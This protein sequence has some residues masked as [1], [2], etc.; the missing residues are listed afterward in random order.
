[1]VFTAAGVVLGGGG[2]ASSAFAGPGA[3]P[4]QPPPAPGADPAGAGPGQGG[5][6]PLHGGPPLPPAAAP[7]GSVPAAAPSG[8]AR[9]RPAG[10]A[11]GTTGAAG[12]TGAASTA[13]TAATAGPESLKG[14]PGIDTPE[15]L[16]AALPALPALPAV[17]VVPVP[18]G[19]ITRAEIIERARAWITAKVPYSTQRYWNDGYRQDCSGYVS[20]AWNLPGNEW[21]GSLARYGIRIEREDLEPGDMLLFHNPD[22]PTTG[23]HVTIFGGWADRA[24]TRYLAYEQAKPYT[25]RQ[26]TPMAYWNNSDRYLAYR[27][28]GLVDGVTGAA[29]PESAA[30]FPGPSVFGPGAVNEYV[31]EL[32]RMLVRRGGERFYATGPG[33]RWGDADRRATAAFQRAQGWRGK[34]ADGMPGAETWRRLVTGQG[35]NIPAGTALP[36]RPQT[37]PGVPA[38]PALP[39]LTGLTGGLPGTPGAPGRTGRTGDAGPAPRPESGSGTTGPYAGYPGA[40]H[41]RPGAVSP[42][43]TRLGERLRQLGYG[44]YYTSGPSP[45]WSEA[46]RRN[47]AAFQRAQGWRGA[48]ADG[49]PGPETW[50]LLFP[51]PGATTKSTTESTTESTAAGT[52]GSAPGGTAPAPTAR[53]G[54]PAD[55][56]GIR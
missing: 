56:P 43:V 48:E 54:R 28:V 23:S 15:G 19:P 51:E 18:G 29:G 50:R 39:D 13:G 20:M 14:L 41:F 36:G 3:P 49:Y 30:L 42:S 21:T 55:G 25:R 7:A 22:N 44:R 4:P 11:A 34:E 16:S 2:P 47:V 27:Y 31:T 45:R 24:R 46:D 6:A 17:P 35:R 40:E 1:M 9:R 32:G 37:L 33:P 53:S 52:T 8:S 10:P 12:S 26:S 38:L 5:T